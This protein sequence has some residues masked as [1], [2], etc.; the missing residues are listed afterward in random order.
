MTRQER[1]EKI[2]KYHKEAIEILEKIEKEAEWQLKV[3]RDLMEPVSAAIYS[4]YEF[5]FE[6]WIDEPHFNVTIHSLVAEVTVRKGLKNYIKYLNTINDLIS[7]AIEDVKECVPE[8][9][10]R[11]EQL[12][13]ELAK[14][15]GSSH[16][17]NPVTEALSDLNIF[18]SIVIDFQE[19]GEAVWDP[20]AMV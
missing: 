14:V 10:R 8:E 6:D 13:H 12:E 11:L 5:T 15:G 20:E 18:N 2:E 17:I 16:N 3:L 4:R 1:F 9:L 7:L 19:N